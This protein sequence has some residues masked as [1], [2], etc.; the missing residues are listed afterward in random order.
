MTSSVVVPVWGWVALTVAIAAMLALDLFLH[1][2]NHVIG[3]Q[4]AA[5]W[6]AVWVGAGLASVCC[7]GGSTAVRSRAP[8]TPAT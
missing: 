1:R 3:F 5:V 4:E 2:D 8:T 6:S 7:C